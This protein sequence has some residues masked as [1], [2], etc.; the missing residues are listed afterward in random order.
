MKLDPHN[1]ITFFQNP[2]IQDY[3]VN[4]QATV[5]LIPTFIKHDDLRPLADQFQ[6]RYIG[7]WNPIKGF[8]LDIDTMELTYPGDPVFIPLVFAPY[9]DEVLWIYDHAIVLIFNTSTQTYQI[10]I[11]D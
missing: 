9:R 8:K 10:S 6:E 1:T 2:N 11:M 7:G 4:I 3:L 5:G